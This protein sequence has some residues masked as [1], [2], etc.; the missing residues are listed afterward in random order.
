MNV[1]TRPA[2]MNV[3]QIRAEFPIL[4]ETVRGKTVPPARRSRAR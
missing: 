3:E 1:T 4:S 2:L